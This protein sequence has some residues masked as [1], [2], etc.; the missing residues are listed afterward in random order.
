MGSSAHNARELAQSHDLLSPVW[1]VRLVGRG[2]RRSPARCAAA[3][4][5][6]L[7]FGQSTFRVDPIKVLPF[8]AVRLT[9]T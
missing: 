9:E 2:S 4:D 1:S 5:A 7:V 6:R 8:L 3:H